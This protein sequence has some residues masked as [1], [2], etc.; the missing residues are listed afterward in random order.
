MLLFTLECI[1]EYFYKSVR[2]LVSLCCPLTAEVFISV[3]NVLVVI[4][5]FIVKFNIKIIMFKK[6]I[7]YPFGTDNLVLK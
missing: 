2:I 1:N 4:F 5:N 3:D 7:G 6:T